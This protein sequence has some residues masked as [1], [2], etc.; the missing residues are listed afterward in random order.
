MKAAVAV[1][2]GLVTGFLAGLVLSEIIGVA[3]FVLVHRAVGIKYLPIY[4]AIAFAVAA[5]VVRAR[6]RRGR[7]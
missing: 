1:V 3:G 4:L 6:I 5:P 2:A 7:R